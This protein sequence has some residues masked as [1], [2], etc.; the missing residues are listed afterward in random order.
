MLKSGKM[1]RRLRDAYNRCVDSAS[2]HMT[3]TTR[4]GDSVTMT[5]CASQ[6]MTARSLPTSALIVSDDISLLT[7][8]VTLYKC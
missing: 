7:V 5:T 3:L 6:L 4:H 2:S 8:V 1:V